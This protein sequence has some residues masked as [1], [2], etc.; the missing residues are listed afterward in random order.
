MAACLPEDA[1]AAQC[2]LF[3]KTPAK[4]WLVALHQ[5]LSIP[6]AARVDSPECTGWSEKEGQLYVQPPLSVL[7]KLLAVRIHV[8]ACP[9][10]SGALRVVPGSHAFGRL[11]PGRAAAIR[12]EQGEQVIPVP[13][14]GALLLRPLLLHASSKTLGSRPRRVL[15]FLFGTR[16]LP[17][18][19]VWQTAI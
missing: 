15:H 7:E 11:E 6:V 1:S 2:T 10:E 12:N 3:D 13:R 5:D 4:N 16:M 8:D 14:G 19:L 9:P 17:S 18:G